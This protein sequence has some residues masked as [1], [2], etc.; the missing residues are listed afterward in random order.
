MCRRTEWALN[1]Q[2]VHSFI[3]ALASKVGK[4]RCEVPGVLWLNH[5]HDSKNEETI[6]IN[7][8]RVELG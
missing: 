5:R 4:I 3:K 7:I 8:W 2:P 1:L 6:Q